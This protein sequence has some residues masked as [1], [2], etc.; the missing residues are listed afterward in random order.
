MKPSLWF[1]I[2]AVLLFFFVLGH[3]AGFLS[4]RP[5]TAEGRAVWNAMNS[6]H[7]RVGS[8]SFSYGGFYV[9]FGLFCTAYLLF[10][11]VLAWQIGSLTNKAPEV[12]GPLGWSLFALQL[13][14]L[15]LSWIYFSLPPAIFSA[16]SAVCIGVGTWMSTAPRN[17]RAMIGAS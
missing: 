14:S 13:A 17:A 16:A 3:T 8:G 9:G 11:A 6:V 12:V 5:S 1:R 10:S 4:F 15:V 2:A 7:F